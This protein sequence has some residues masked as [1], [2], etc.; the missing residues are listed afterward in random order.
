M[1]QSIADEKLLDDIRRVHANL[2]SPP[3]E[4][5]Y[6]EYGEYSV[7]AV[8]RA[9]GKYTAGRE[10]AGVP[11][12]DMRGGQN[13]ISRE[14]LLE[15]LQRLS[16]IVD[17][18]P[19]RVDL[20]MHGKFAEQPYRREFGSWSA[21]LLAAGND[22]DDLNRPGRQVAKR[23][24]VNCTICGV[25]QERLESQ[26]RSAKNVFCSQDCLHTWRSESFTGES[27]PLTDRVD[28]EC[29]W[30]EEPLSRVPAVDE[31]REHH[32]CSY[33]C[34]GEW[35]SEHR[36]GENAPAWEGGGHL[37]RGPNWLS[38]REK[39]IQRDEYTCQRCECTESEH[40]EEYGRQ[41]S[42]HHIRPVREFYAEIDNGQPDFNEVNALSNLVTLCVDCHRKIEGL[43]VTPQFIVG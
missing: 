35:R 4:N 20:E 11:E 38:Q 37:Y 25:E 6:R 13:K 19:R 5:D 28:V 29:E 12:T 21:A 3:S 41:L 39:A 7:S 36:S 18:T 23:V 30:C 2:G 14:D 22:Y 31:A 24:T 1:A 16:K 8:R 34:M 43:P 10:A 26:I 17:G 27:H 40:F 33:E 42:V 9:F 15:E 32:F